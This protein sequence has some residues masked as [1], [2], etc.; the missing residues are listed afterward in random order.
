MRFLALLIL[1]LP[2][3]A[4][5][6]S[7]PEAYTVAR[8]VA[9]GPHT[10]TVEIG[11]ER[12]EAELP[13]EFAGFHVGQRVVVY[14]A[15]GRA[16]IAEPYRI[17]YLWGLLG[18]FALVTLTLGRGKGLRG[19]LGTA[20]SMG[21]LAFFVV[22]QISSGNNPLL[23]TFVG[24]FGILALSIYFVHGVNRKTTAALIGTT[25][26]TIVALVLASL[27]TEWMQFT[28]LTS[29]ETFLARFQL[30]G[31]L[32]LVALYLAGVVVGALGALNDVTVTQAAVVQALVQANPRY[33]LRELYNRGMTVGFDHIG[34]LVNTL[35]LAYAAGSL[36]LLLLISRSDVPLYL[37]VNNETFAAEIVTM[38]VGSLALVL[39]VPL[40]TLVAAWL[41]RG[42]RLDYIDRRWPEA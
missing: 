23:V 2:V 36:P 10:A 33:G 5:E 18:L 13:T 42:R 15:G 41:L 35:V 8:I 3:W 12:K 34:S 30:G 38:L 26:A 9:L 39:A 28:G 24:A 7:A 4:Q 22:P 27:L 31:Q 11:G 25:L 1:F 19:L 37:L 32:D 16:Y 20:A 40:T 6:P 17:P 21:V 29:E 14:Q